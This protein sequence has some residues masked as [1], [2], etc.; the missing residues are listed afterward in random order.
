MNTQYCFIKA[1]LPSRQELQAAV[2]ALGFGLLLDPQL[3]L[4]IDEG[5]SPC[6]LKG[7]DDIGFEL[8]AGSIEDIFEDDEPFADKIGDRTT[9]ISFSW[10]S[11]F[12]D[13]FASLVTTLA[14]IKSFDAVTTFDCETTDSVEDIEAGI[15]DCLK[16]LKD[17]TASTEGDADEE[18]YG[19]GS[20]LATEIMQMLEMLG[21]DMTRKTDIAFYMYFET[22]GNATNASKAII[23]EYSSAQIE[24]SESDEQSWLCYV[25]LQVMPSQEA[26][27]GLG[28]LLIATTEQYK[29][30]FD[31]WE[32]AGN[33]LIES[34]FEVDY[35]QI[36]HE[37][38]NTVKSANAPEHEYKV[39]TSN[40]IDGV[41]IPFYR[42]TQTLLEGL[43]FERLCDVENLTIG[44]QF[45]EVVAIRVMTHAQSKTIAAFYFIPSIELGLCEFESMFASGEI[46]IS[47]NSPAAF[48]TP[49][50]PKILKEL[51]DETVSFDE[52][53]NM[54][55]QLINNVKDKLDVSDVITINNYEDVVKLQ[56]KQCEYQYEHLKSIGWVT[57]E[58][59]ITQ[60]DGDEQTATAVY[61]AI[62]EILSNS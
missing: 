26:L 1:D 33:D 55:Q 14:L 27:N 3:D 41:G 42:E 16:E 22:E 8:E 17:N 12:A 18:K 38:L 36:A 6:R 45:G 2:D 32:L 59:L 11:G 29:G 43:G 24:V 53:F 49:T 61:Q 19:S 52:M 57:K 37:I 50:H 20:E 5:F 56:N 30:D 62:Q 25:L 51:Y 34:A 47:S 60:A 31:G 23:D 40:C 48:D 35:E 9:Y 58:W 28:E 4:S 10:G 15:K 13:C 7:F 46:I 21:T 44:K 54:H 39:L